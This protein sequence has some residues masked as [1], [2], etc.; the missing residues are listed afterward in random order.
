MP[1]GKSTF[2]DIK[3][4]PKFNQPINSSDIVAMQ[5]RVLYVT[6]EEIGELSVHALD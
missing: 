5:S 4:G 1:L 3:K 6:F 2:S